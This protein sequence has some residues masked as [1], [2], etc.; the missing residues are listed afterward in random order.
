MKK[1][2]YYTVVLGELLL[3]AGGMYYFYPLLPETMAVHFGFNGQPDGWQTKSSF[4]IFYSLLVLGIGI[5]FSVMAHIFPKLPISLINLPHKEYW[6]APERATSSFAFLSGFFYQMTCGLTLF[7]G[8]IFADV[9]LANLTPSLQLDYTTFISV[10]VLFLGFVLGNVV[11][12]YRR[13]NI[14]SGIP[15]H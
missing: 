14:N 1:S 8:L 4:Y 12:L 6:F 10:L 15:S 9:C 5:L 13:F 11:R 2:V 7:F 3:I